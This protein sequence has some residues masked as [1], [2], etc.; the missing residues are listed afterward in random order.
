[1]YSQWV[2]VVPWGWQPLGW[3]CVFEL[4]SPMDVL[5]TQ[6]WKLL[7]KGWLRV[8]TVQFISSI[9]PPSSQLCCVITEPGCS[10]FTQLH[11][12][13]CSSQSQHPEPLVLPTS[14]VAGCV[15]LGTIMEQIIHWILPW[16]ISQCCTF[17]E[18][19]TYQ[20]VMSNN[21]CTG[22]KEKSLPPPHCTSPAQEVI[23]SS[24]VT[25][26]PLCVTSRLHNP[27]NTRLIKNVFLKN[28]H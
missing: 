16:K 27:S 24:E 11:L 8:T 20:W 12:Q 18:E 19:Q 13:C 15:V 2:V 21:N 9:G 28:S 14:K 3:R 23:E 4:R 26:G 6:N 22:P 5:L 10:V 7:G 25:S 17:S 1:M